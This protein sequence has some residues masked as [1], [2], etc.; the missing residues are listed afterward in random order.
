MEFDTLIIFKENVNFHHTKT[1]AVVMYPGILY[2]TGCLTST[3]IHT[4]YACQD[5]CLRVL[6]TDNVEHCYP[7]A[8]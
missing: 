4:I 5:N 6:L 1:I 2:F 8:S 7:N 3:I